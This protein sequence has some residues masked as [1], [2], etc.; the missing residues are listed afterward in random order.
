MVKLSMEPMKRIITLHNNYC[1]ISL[2]Q[3]PVGILLDSRNAATAGKPNVA[4]VTMVLK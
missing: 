3:S 1:L 2:I 4:C